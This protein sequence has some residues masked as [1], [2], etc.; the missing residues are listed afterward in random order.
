MS[1][2]GHNDR[3]RADPET[4]PPFWLHTDAEEG[5][6]IDPRVLEVVRKNWSWAFRLIARRLR[7]GTRAAEIVERV[8]ADVSKRLSADPSVARNLNGYFKTALGNTVSTVAARESR[9]VYEGGARELEANHH[10]IAAD[11]T[12]VFEDDL[13]LR[14]LIP[15]MNAQ[16]RRIL[17][18]RQLDFSWKDIAKRLSITEKQARSRFYYGARQA[19]SKLLEAQAMRARTEDQIDGNQ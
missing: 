11:W 14:A 19:Y 13:V 4:V 5:H 17:G 7:D 2:H 6:A 3:G 12:K 10:L 16:V 1:D 9:I 8:A 18:Y 15:H